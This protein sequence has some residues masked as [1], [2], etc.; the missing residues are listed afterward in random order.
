VAAV[1]P[2]DLQEMV[3]LVVLASFLLHIPLDK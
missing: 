2:M 3:D 1:V